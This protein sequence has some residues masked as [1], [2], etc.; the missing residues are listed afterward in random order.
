MK[1]AFPKKKINF[2]FYGSE[3]SLKK[4]NKIL[5]NYNDNKIEKFLNENK[6][7]INKL[8]KLTSKNDNYLIY[9]NIYEEIIKI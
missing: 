4:L 1:I 6:M 5:K 7:R 9:E 2:E 8:K 3:V